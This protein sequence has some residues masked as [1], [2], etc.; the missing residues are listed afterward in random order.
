M[1]GCLLPRL[2]LMMLTCRLRAGRSKVYRLEPQFDRGPTISKTQHLLG[3]DYCHWLQYQIGHTV[4]RPDACLRC[5]RERMNR[6]QNVDNSA[7]DSPLS[8]MSIAALQQRM[9]SLRSDL[10]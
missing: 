6:L 9:R 2:R 3:T 4:S 7:G 1:L 8:K 5:C 10:Q